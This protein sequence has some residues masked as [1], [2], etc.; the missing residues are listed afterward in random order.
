MTVFW[1]QQPGI[2]LRQ[3]AARPTW[4]ALPEASASTMSSVWRLYV[5]RSVGVKSIS[6]R[7]WRSSPSEVMFAARRYLV[8]YRPVCFVGV[9]CL[10]SR[11]EPTSAT[12]AMTHPGGRP[13]VASV[14]EDRPHVRSNEGGPC[15]AQAT[16][17]SSY[18][19]GQH[20][21]TSNPEVRTLQVTRGAGPP[22]ACI[23]GDDGNDPT[24][25]H[26]RMP[27]GYGL[28]LSKSRVGRNAF[29]SLCV[30][31]RRPACLTRRRVCG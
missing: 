7:S 20:G 26:A 9:R 21:L 19:S 4:V 3:M 2:S 17:L 28:G 11:T 10:P 16:K 12:V 5:K 14:M 30:R 1:K 13:T 8:G 18:T 22:D 24:L 15:A 29:R 31:A 27:E 6:R 23:R 25:G